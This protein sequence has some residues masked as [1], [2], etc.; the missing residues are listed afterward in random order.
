[1]V[2]TFLGV[3]LNSGLGVA[4]GI[5]VFIGLV[6]AIGFLLYRIRWADPNTSASDVRMILLVLIALALTV[7]IGFLIVFVVFSETQTQPE[8]QMGLIVVAS[9]AALMT[10]LFCMAAGFKSMDMADTKQAL[11]LPE[12]SVRAMIALILILVFILFGIYLFRIVG[13]GTE[14]LVKRVDEKPTADLL[15]SFKEK[16]VIKVFAKETKIGTDSK[17][18]IWV[19]RSISDDAKRLAQQLLTTV[20]TLVV[21]VSGF[22]FGSTSTAG[23]AASA[24]AGAAGATPFRVENFTPPDGTQGTTVPLT[25]YG[26]GLKQVKSVRLEGQGRFMEGKVAQPVE[27]QK[28]TAAF[29]LENGTVGDWHVVVEFDDGRRHQPSATFKIKNA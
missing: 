10:L 29:V 27:D 7:L 1:M 2:P 24:T 17:Y 26:A 15:D 9:I 21:A 14:T 25:I 12:G 22:Y 16:D 13:G 4:L 5:V 28:L 11:G 18:D 8:T 20:G 3:T 6:F 23:A 19:I